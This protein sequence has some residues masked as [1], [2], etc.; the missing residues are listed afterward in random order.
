MSSPW[1]LG[2]SYILINSLYWIQSKNGAG[3]KNCL[4]NKIH[5]DCGKDKHITSQWF[6]GY[7][8][9]IFQSCCVSSSWFIQVGCATQDCLIRMGWV[10]LICLRPCHYLHLRKNLKYIAL[11][12]SQHPWIGW[13]CCKIIFHI[14][15]CTG[16]NKRGGIYDWWYWGIWMFVSS[17]LQFD[18]MIWT[19][20][21]FSWSCFQWC[22]PFLPPSIIFNCLL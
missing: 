19:F 15:P 21:Y 22:P 14:V 11:A 18:P 17:C 5:S 4:C 10:S 3:T 7:W 2:N 8:K 13:R 12:C 20:S 9:L 6:R 1:I 16:R